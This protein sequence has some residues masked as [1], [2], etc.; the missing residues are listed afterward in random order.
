VKAVGNKKANE[1]GIFDMSGSLWECCWDV[2][3]LN[4]S[5]RRVRSSSFFDG[6][7]SCTVAYRDNYFPAGDRHSGYGFRLARSLGQ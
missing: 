1:L 4:P 5:Y 6:A 2:Y 3:D 7:A